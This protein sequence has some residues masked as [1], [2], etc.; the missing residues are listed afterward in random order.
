[1][2]VE[3]TSDGSLYIASSNSMEDFTLE[4]WWER[5]QDG[6]VIFGIRTENDGPPNSSKIK[7]TDS[8]GLHFNN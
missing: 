3:F 8:K 5:F 7:K 4:A 6:K 1:M 2:H